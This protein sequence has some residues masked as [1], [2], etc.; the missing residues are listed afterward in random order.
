MKAIA[1]A[2]IALL[3]CVTAIAKSHRSSHAPTSSK[4]KAWSQHP[5][6]HRIPRSPAAKHAFVRAHPC[7]STWRTLGACPGYIIDH[8]KP[9]ACGGADAPGNMQ[10]QKVYAAKQKDKWERRG[11]R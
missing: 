3:L 4:P 9:L 11:C 10:W 5:Y 1:T 8:V 2:L 6:H 7:P